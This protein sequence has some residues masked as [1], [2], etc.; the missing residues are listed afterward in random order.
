MR[1]A[2]YYLGLSALVLNP[3][4]L[5]AQEPAADFR[6]ITSRFS[7]R[8]V[9][10]NELTIAQ[11]N[12]GRMALDTNRFTALVTN[13]GDFP[14]TLGL[15]LRAVPGLWVRAN[16]QHGYRFEIPARSERLIEAAYV[17]RR[18]TPEATLRVFFGNPRDVEGSIDVVERF[19][20]TTL[21]VGVG[22][23]AA[24]DPRLAFDTLSTE[25][26]DVIAWRGSAGARKMPAIAADRERALR[27]IAELLAVTFTGRIRLVLYPDS[28]TKTNQTGHIGSGFASGR[29][30]IEIFNDSVQLD[31]YH[32]VA[33]IVAGERG[34]PPALLDEGFAVYVS[35]SL[36]A[37][38]LKYLGAPGKT[39]TQV[40][41]RYLQSGA[42]IPLNRLFRF[43]D[44]G[45]D[46]T[47]PPI[48]YPEAAS[49]T[50]F[51]IE[52]Y[53]I[54]RF[55]D[56][57]A[58]LRNTTNAVELRRNE[59]IFEATYGR[60]IAAIERAWRAG[61]PCPR[62]ER[63]P[64]GLLLD[65]I[66]AHTDPSP[67]I[68]RYDLVIRPDF[69]TRRLRLTAT[70]DIANPS[71]ETGFTF[72]LADWYDSVV[73][74][75]RAGRAA[76]E[77]GAGA[78]TVRV[79]RASAQER[80]VFTL[81]GT[82]GKSAGDDRPVIA[83]SSIY[84]LWSDRFYPVDFDDW[85]I[86]STRIEL[87][88]G[89]QVFAPGRRVATEDIGARHV[90]RYATSMPIRAASVLADARWVVSERTV[91]G[92]RMRTLLYPASRQHGERIFT[93]SADVLDFYVSR[94]GPYAFDEFTFATVEGIFARR[95]VAGGVIYESGYLDKEMRTTGHDAHETALLW[96]F[97]TLAGRGP[98]SYQWTEGFGDYAEM[99]YDEARGLPVPSDF[100]LY[101]RGYLR[102]AGTSDELSITAPRG[103]LRENFVHGRLP[104][105]MHVLRF[106]VGDSAFNRGVW[107][108]FDQW[109]F[110]SF[111]LGEFVAT[112]AEGTRQSL[113]WW[114][115]EWLERRGVPELSWRAD[116]TPDSGG[117]RVAVSLRQSA[118]LYHLPLEIGIESPGGLRVERVQLNEPAGEYRF[119]LA[120]VP[121]RVVIDPRRWLLAK[122]TPQ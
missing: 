122:I 80:L 90:E 113:D 32:E 12:L 91:R 83:D 3:P 104:W 50:A 6:T 64:A 63:S 28:A 42:L 102:T 4:P 111:T 72:L 11:M 37:D 89:F 16:W 88:R 116:I 52:Q 79:P 62:T 15:S 30:I 47:L 61:L 25:H 77:R 46:S 17:F 41:C 22:N 39:V 74:Q 93:T 35:Q 108:L 106:A 120:A 5:G 98:G 82:P 117:Y 96:W 27:Q 119:W 84:L 67:D 33:H 86:V 94:F 13:K 36:G 9:E 34:S 8:V 53:G 31:P 7:H 56:V 97:W 65:K 1:S 114:R 44:I 26:F 76:V 118:A 2:L 87:P 115:T 95:A 110:R 121:T 60:D 66:G 78:V 100:E 70:V 20:D 105:L 109:R 10:T 55:R 23:P 29:T 51:L 48:A 40:V 19:Y 45:S 103:P 54:E 99:L 71:R 18:M 112:L 107:L 81:S 58:R 21:A 69:A 14:L 85:A 68:Q 49:V 73:V 43:T 24:S 92:R 101:R 38:A 59:E 75:S 57:Y